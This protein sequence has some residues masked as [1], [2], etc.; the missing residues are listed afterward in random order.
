MGGS[1]ADCL[2]DHGC[3]SRFKDPS[4]RKGRRPNERLHLTRSF[5]LKYPRLYEVQ[6]RHEV[7]APGWARK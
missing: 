3:E 4:A 5:E 1:C 2:L 6:V 7:V